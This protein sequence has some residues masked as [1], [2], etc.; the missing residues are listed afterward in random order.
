MISVLLTDGDCIH[1]MDHVRDLAELEQ[2]NK[3]ARDYT[4]GT[5]S[6]IINKKI[7]S[8]LSASEWW[9]FVQVRDGSIIG[10]DQI[11]PRP[12]KISDY[13]F[14]MKKFLRRLVYTGLAA[15]SLAIIVRIIELMN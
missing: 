15:I 7:K 6:W 4:N 13:R 1:K 3:A 14:S 2:W 5:F 8:N 11:G 9:Q 10:R 12:V